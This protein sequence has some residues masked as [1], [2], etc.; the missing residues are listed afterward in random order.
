MDHFHYNAGQYYAEN[1]A[2][3]EIARHLPTPFYCYSTAT[4]RHH[5]AVFA[6][7]LA[8]LNPMI[9]FAVKAN[10]NPHV[11]R[12]LREAGAGADVVS[13]GEIM[14]ALAAGIDPQHIVFS[15]VGKT[16]DEIAFAV[17]K[18]VFQFNV[19]S[20]PELHLINEVAGQQ[21]VCA[22]IALRVNPDVDAGT[23]EKITT[24]R[25]DSKF[26]IDIDAAP[27]LYALAATLPH[28]RIQGV[29]VHIGSQLTALEPFQKAYARVKLFVEAMRANGVPIEV[30]D[31]GG[32]LG[33]P[34][35]STLASPPHPE[36]YG[37]MIVEAMRGL[38][39]RYVFEPG[40]LI[41]GNAGILVTSV[42][43]VKQTAHTEF[44]IIDA[45][46]NDLARPAMYGA[47]H[48]I[49]P[50][51][52]AASQQSY[53]VVGPVCESS[54][55]FA[56]AARLPVL[57]AGALLA[58][59]SSGAYGAS[60]SSTYNCRPLVPEV[61]VEGDR[62]RIIRPRKSYDEMLADYSHSSL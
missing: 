17:S 48:E 56:K 45:G 34:Y 30:V 15:G 27:E 14:L 36:A 54:D 59:R 4:L 7:S 60:M 19:E 9:C 33:I 38:E 11:L 40:R 16:R 26:G 28:V 55:V 6:D 29:S 3:A 52:E 18:G 31:L 50:V 41:A 46:M 62:F 44:A 12:V 13:Q 37:A 1:V 47:H 43:Y 2:I 25:K 57:D 51:I 42:L 22:P 8:P 32:G 10:G 21:G 23:H 49:V 61:L 24:G 5:V 20:L 39:A 58:I 35:D 53:H